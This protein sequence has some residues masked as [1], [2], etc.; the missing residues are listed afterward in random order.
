MPDSNMSNSSKHIVILGAGLSGLISALSLAQTDYKITLVEYKNINAKDFYQDPRST[1]ITSYSRKFFQNIGIYEHLKPFTEPINNIYVVN[2]KSPSMISFASSSDDKMGELILNNKFKEILLLQAKSHK[3]IEIID[4]ANYEDITSNKDQ[5]IIKIK[6]NK[7]NNTWLIQAD[8][9]LVCDG[10]HSK[11]KKKFFQSSISRQYNQTAITFTVNHEKHH[12][13][14]AVEHFMQGGPFAILPLKGGYQSS[15]V[16]TMPTAKAKALLK[17]DQGEFRY[18]LQSDF[19]PFLGNVDIEGPVAAFPLSAWL[20]NKYYYNRILLI[21]D[22]AHRIHPLAGQGL[23]QGLK[24]IE[25]LKEILMHNA[26]SDR[27]LKEYNDK[28]YSDNHIMLEI[29]DQLNRIFEPESKILEK[30]R[31]IGFKII[32]NTPMLKK[33]LTKYAAG[34]RK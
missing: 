25:C 11:A 7:T 1:A 21:A 26:I 22:S 29:T 28:R 32:E 33:Q 10:I 2:N 20:A 13:G 14:T 27:A 30:I 8:L 17:I 12:E 5:S 16:W 6:S 31:T 9:T 3:N 24:D 19:G 18:I 4:Q 23:N 34:A 15:V